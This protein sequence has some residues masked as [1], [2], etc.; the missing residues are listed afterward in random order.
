MRF[1]IALSWIVLLLILYYVGNFHR[2]QPPTEEEELFEIKD[3]VEVGD[4]N[5][6]INNE[7]IWRAAKN[8][9]LGL[10]QDYFPAGPNTSHSPYKH[11]MIGSAPADNSTSVEGSINPLQSPRTC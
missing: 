9:K 1:S 5:Q 6:Q 3:S 8:R 10:F 2:F 11:K 7:L 4:L